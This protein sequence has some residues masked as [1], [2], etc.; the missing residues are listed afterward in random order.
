MDHSHLRAK[1]RELMAAGVL[2]ANPPPITRSTPSSTPGKRA[3]HGNGA[4]SVAG[5]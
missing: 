4:K 1:V 2:P 3:N 5:I